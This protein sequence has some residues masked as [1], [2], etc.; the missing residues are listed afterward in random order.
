M[1][2]PLDVLHHLTNLL[3]VHPL[4]CAPKRI[5]RITVITTAMAE[6]LLQKI[7]CHGYFIDLNFR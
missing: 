6:R 4:I 5:G 3:H 2:L 1:G 7:T